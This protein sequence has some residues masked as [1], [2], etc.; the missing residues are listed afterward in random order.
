MP[1]QDQ[2]RQLFTLDRQLRGLRRR[3]D[4]AT[5]R[6][7]AQQSRLEQFQQQKSELNDQ[8]KLNQA[9]TSS[10]EH[11]AM[12]VDQRVQKLRD[13]MNS[14]TS[15]KEYQALLVEANTIKLEK[16]KLEDQAL[17]KMSEVEQQQAE[18]GELEEKCAQQQRVVEQAQS[19]VEAARSEVGDQLEALTAERAAAA[20]EVP[21]DTR[22]LFEHLSD[23]HDGEALA[24]IEEADRRRMEYHCGGCFLQLPIDFV[25]TLLS[26][27]DE[28]VVC[29]ACKRILYVEPQLKEA[30]S[31][32]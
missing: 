25:S 22:Q 26:R 18:L 16:A 4:S 13:Q 2:L 30:L 9:T 3:L 21:R 12:A 29:P 11:E 19:E 31:S 20:A 6:L 23:A 14:V 24:P 27:P 8:V 32:K 17:E 10:L 28:V 15:N 7:N 1:L 5:H